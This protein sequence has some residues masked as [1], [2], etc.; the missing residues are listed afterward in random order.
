MPEF[1]CR[2][3]RPKAKFVKELMKKYVI[4]IFLFPLDEKGWWL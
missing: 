2:F 4:T 3:S 1:H